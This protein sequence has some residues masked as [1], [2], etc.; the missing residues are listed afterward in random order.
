[1]IHLTRRERFST[2]ALAVFVAV[3][4]AYSLVVSP[5]VERIETL[6]RLIPEKQAE[7]QRLRVMSSEYIALRDSYDQMKARI[8]SQD[9]GSELLSFLESLIRQNKLADKLV[10]MNQQVLQ[11]NPGYTEIVVDVKFENVPLDSL[12]D[13][14][15]KVESAQIPARISAMHIRRNPANPHLL[16]T[17]F[18]IHSPKVGGNGPLRG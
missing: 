13:F 9:K 12:I 11:D 15:H 7:L 2:V 4:S 5:A 16:D 8:A 17:D 6:N 14:L 10:T 18:K 1:M 3:W